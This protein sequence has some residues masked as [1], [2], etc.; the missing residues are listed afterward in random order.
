MLF[1]SE[2]RCHYERSALREV[3]CQ[4][5]FP[6]IPALAGE[7]IAAL[8]SALTATFPQYSLRKE[9]LPPR[10]VGV[11]TPE[12]RLELPPAINNHQ[13][14]SED[15]SRR[16][17]VT[18]NMLVLSTRS[19]R[20]WEEF[21]AHLDRAL[22]TFLSLYHPTAFQRI[23]LRYLNVFSRNALGLQTVPFRELFSA[24]YLG[25][26]GAED[27][28]EGSVLKSAQELEF[29]LDNS[30]VAKLRSG[31]SRLK[32]AAPN[33]PQDPEVKFLL[34]MTLTMPIATEPFLVA[35]VLETLHAH[36]TRVFRGA[37]LPPLH[38]A[39]LPQA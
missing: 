24:P 37:I 19:Y 33:A 6:A 23:D 32:K 16:L 7:D 31:P 17:N 25:I 12:A 15:G 8:K 22:S 27:L 21:S 10:L 34:D 30:S 26:L 2:P 18:Q 3:V 35:G 29:K 38:Q 36:S 4:L 5:L 28:S 20:S 39:M 14:L 11:G 1:S 13:F 9:K